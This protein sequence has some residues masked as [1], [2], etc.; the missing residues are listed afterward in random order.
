MM[1]CTTFIFSFTPTKFKKLNAT[2]Q[3]EITNVTELQNIKNNLAGD[4]ILK[5]DIIIDEGSTWT[6][7][8]DSSS[9]FTG[10]FDGNGYAIVFG[11]EES[12]VTM[13]AQYSGLFGY[14]NASSIQN[15]AIKGAI[16]V[17][18]TSETYLGGIIG[19]LKGVSSSDTFAISNCYN[20]AN[21]KV[22]N[23][24]GNIHLGGL[25][26]FLEWKTIINNCFN[27]GTITATLS[28]SSSSYIVATGGIAGKGDFNYTSGGDTYFYNC[29]NAG[30]IIS[31][32]NKTIASGIVGY[33]GVFNNCHNVG[34]I[35][36]A[37]TTAYVNPITYAYDNG[38]WEP[39]TV[40]VSGENNA[41]ISVTEQDLSVTST[42]V[43]GVTY[44]KGKML[45]K[46][47]ESLSINEDI[48]FLSDS[49]RTISLMWVTTFL[50]KLNNV[51]ASNPL[52]LSH[53]TERDIWHADYA[54]DENLWGIDN[55]SGLLV[56][57]NQIATPPIHNFIFN[58]E[59][60]NLKGVI[61]Y[62]LVNNN[63]SY[64]I[65]NQYLVMNGQ[66]ISLELTAETQYRILIC[67]SF[68]SQITMEQ[69]NGVL[70]GT[71][72]DFNSNTSATTNHTFTISSS[73][74]SN[75]YIL[76]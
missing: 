18:R 19:Y 23:T 27:S 50:D 15:L 16:S 20:L 40:Y 32:G 39:G 34:E 72:Y 26:G 38:Y 69:G 75:N 47:T 68:L 21:I 13:T 12:P 24:S 73:S 43:D 76:I 37:G 58:L 67:G 74:L 66:V 28:S 53:F 35:I 8:G 9:P 17:S 54:W 49:T 52:I 65:V 60:D 31:S 41:Y 55:K 5:N 70:N 63:V 4:Y 2:S 36:S 22:S 62:I 56:F 25:I 51:T 14:G 57:I 59:N 33:H 48:G 7:I 11:S 3:S 6:P 42:T 46:F 44:S 71:M 45:P 29:Y 64:E 30:K 61:I 1:V 10:T